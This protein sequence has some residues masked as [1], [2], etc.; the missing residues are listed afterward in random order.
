MSRESVLVQHLEDRGA[1][2]VEGRFGVDEACLSIHIAELRIA[3]HNKGRESEQAWAEQGNL[4]SHHA[5]LVSG[6]VRVYG[7]D[8]SCPD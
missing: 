3:G 1:R 6:I 8:R 2:R 4:Q 5:C 7:V